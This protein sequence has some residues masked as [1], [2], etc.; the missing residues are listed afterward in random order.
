MK[1]EGEGSRGRRVDGQGPRA[2]ILPPSALNLLPS[3]LPSSAI[4][5]PWPLKGPASTRSPHSPYEAARR[6]PAVR[7]RETRLT[8]FDESAASVAPPSPPTEP[9]P[10]TVAEV[11]ALVNGALDRSAELR[12]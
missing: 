3:L 6:L 5:H 1:E 10:R 4:R 9:E 8:A 12:D 7:P 11:L 2:E